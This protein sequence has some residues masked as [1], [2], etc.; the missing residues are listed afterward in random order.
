MDDLFSMAR[1]PDP[2]SA[3]SGEALSRFQEGAPAR[4]GNDVNPT[5]LVRSLDTAVGEPRI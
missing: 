1:G 4:A 3:F 5:T 2:E